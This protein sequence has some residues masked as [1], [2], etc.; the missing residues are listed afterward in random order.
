MYDRLDE[1]LEGAQE[2]A[3]CAAHAHE[4]MRAAREDLIVSQPALGHDWVEITSLSSQLGLSLSQ[5]LMGE[6]RAA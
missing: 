6:G 3:A 4:W 1:H 5:D 2:E